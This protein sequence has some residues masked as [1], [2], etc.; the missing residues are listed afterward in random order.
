M[1][2]G[3]PALAAMLAAAIAAVAACNRTDEAGIAARVNGRE[4]ALARLSELVPG[5]ER[6]REATARALEKA[7][8]QELL[9]QGAIDKKLDRDPRVAQSI[10]AARRQILAQAY[11]DRVVAPA[12]ATREEIRDFYERN[13]ALFA[14]RRIYRLQEV[15]VDGA[16]DKLEA[17]N[18]RVAATRDLSQL[19]AWLKERKLTFSLASAV[20]P[21]EQVPLNYLPRLAQM[22]EGEIAVFPTQ[23][24][25]SVVQLVQ[26]QDAALSEPQAAPVIERFIASRRRLQLAEQ[27]VIA[28]REKAR[29]E[30]VGEYALA[31]RSPSSISGRS[32]SGPV[33]RGFAEGRGPATEPV[34]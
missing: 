15:S 20:K 21:A 4:L 9:V 27:H 25:A 11:V 29:I 14:Q 22:K 30:Y 8:D 12:A 7:V 1:R 3:K 33:G 5:T 32:A 10:E 31:A 26:F 13:P 6:A 17:L 18:Q 19:T 28:L 24:G 23:T 34:R 2:A 16:A